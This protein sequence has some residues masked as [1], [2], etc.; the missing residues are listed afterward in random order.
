MRKVAILTLPLIYNYGAI[1]QAYALQK[2]IQQLGCECWLIDKQLPIYPYYRR[3]LSIISRIF[4]KYFKG[5]KNYEVIPYWPSYCDIRTISQETRK[6]V[7]RYIVPKTEP[8]FNLTTKSDKFDAYI[9]GSDQ[10]WRKSV[11]LKIHDYL[12]GFVSTEKK[13]SSYAASFGVDYW[14]FSPSETKKIIKYFKSLD[15]ITV[16]EDSAIEILKEKVGINATQVLDPTLLLDKDKYDSLISKHPRRSNEPFIFSYILD[17]NNEKDDLCN[18]LSQ[19]IKMPIYSIMPKSS[20]GYGIDIADC[21]YRPVEDWIS[22]FRDANIIITD[23]FHGSVFSIIY[24]KPFFVL[25]NKSRGNT[26]LESLLRMFNLQDRIIDSQKELRERIDAKIDWNE[27]N[28]LKGKKRDY[29]VS[30]LKEMIK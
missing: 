14:E 4:G 19:L 28:S 6:F 12:L 11:T 18:M 27:V 15:I 24:N 16:R 2:T 30:I 20:P 3:P 17:E 8:V 13:K 5:E 23:S 10:V 7:D 9:V 1:L 26:R 22:G 29:S 25:R 21:I